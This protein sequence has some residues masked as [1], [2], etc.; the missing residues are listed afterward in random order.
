MSLYT[1]NSQK[2]PKFAGDNTEFKKQTQPSALYQSFNKL[3]F[4]YDYITYYRAT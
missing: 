1:F 2:L 4:T 3:I